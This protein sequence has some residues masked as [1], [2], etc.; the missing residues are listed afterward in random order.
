MRTVDLTGRPEFFHGIAALEVAERGLFAARMTPELREFYRRQSEMWY[1][2]AVGGAGVR[3][4]FRTAA[5]KLAAHFALG[6]RSRDFFGFDVVCGKQLIARL[7]SPTPRDEFEFTAALPGSGI[8]TVEIHLP[9][10]VESFLRKLELDDD[11][12]MEPVT[13]PEAPMIFI[14]DSITQGMEAVAPGE[15]YAVQLAQKL[16]RDSINLAVGG[17]RMLAE[18]TRYALDYRWDTAILAYGVNDAAGR[19]PLAAFREQTRR[20]LTLLTARAEAQV[21][22]FTPIPWPN[23]PVKHPVEFALEQYREILLECA[24]AFPAVRVVDGFTLLEN[25]A[26]YFADGVHPNAEGMARMAERLFR[27]FTGSGAESAR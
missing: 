9:Y 7:T 21:W 20:C 16:G 27:R 23:Q 13:F 2:R 5:R 6:V 26:R 14:G 25:E 22:I 1:F 10:E 17:M 19:T 4:V 11:G 3:I 15:T 8:R 12:V 24:A 18:P